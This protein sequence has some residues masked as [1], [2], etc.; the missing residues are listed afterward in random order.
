MLR[1]AGSLDESGLLMSNGC[2]KMKQSM[3]GEVVQVL[4]VRK[5]DAKITKTLLEETGSFHLNFR[6]TDSLKCDGCLAVPIV[7]TT[8][9]A[10]TDSILKALPATAVFGVGP[11][12]CPYSASRMNQG[13]SKALHLGY[14][15]T[16][17]QQALVEAFLELCTPDT[18][19][20]IR[21]SIRS[22]SRLIC[23]RSLE[24]IG[25]DRTIVLPEAALRPDDPSLASV[26][27]KVEISSP[28]PFW[29]AVW[30]HLAR[31]HRSQRV[32]RRAAIDPSSSIRQSHFLILWPPP[33]GDA[34]DVHS[35]PGG[36]G[37]ITVTEQGIRQSFD[38]TRV[39]F[40][41][42]N[43]SEKIRFGTLVRPGEKVLDMYGGIGYFTLPALVHGR[44]SHVVVCEW[45]PDALQALEINLREN[46]VQ[47]RALVLK[48]D[49][50]L[51]AVEHHLVDQFD[52]V[53]L[54]LLPSSEGGWPTAVRAVKYS[55]GGRLHVHGNVPAVEACAW[56][57]W[58]C[59]RLMEHLCD[60]E[61]IPRMECAVVGYHLE[62]VKSFAPT[63]NHYVADVYVGP[64]SGFTEVVSGE[65]E[66]GFVGYRHPDT[67]AWM[68]CRRLVDAPSCAL[69]PTGVLRQEWMA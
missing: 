3:A 12:F 63:V 7:S 58:L 26:L 20:D 30:S 23:P 46:G 36:A 35:G 27:A 5:G 47:G 56:F 67:K 19:H 31:L 29:Q 44:A 18:D 2:R 43:I 52:R 11:Q 60:L 21:T 13:Q 53:V 15:T 28:T 37:W 55:S 17:V 42:G 1:F 41:R 34:S 51:S 14:D 65:L 61:A 54:G 49:C 4:H 22:L 25:D 33:P 48:G 40:S 59:V 50:R 8:D 32:V 6:V 9:P 69:S 57:E 64:P 66:A 10:R 62:K 45:N 16:L 24:T 68:E 38:L 39:M